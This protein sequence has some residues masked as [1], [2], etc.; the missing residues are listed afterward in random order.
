[1]PYCSIEYTLRKRFEFVVSISILHQNTSKYF[2]KLG[3][4][5]IFPQKDLG[6]SG[7]IGYQSKITFV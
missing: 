5:S 7:V 4:A 3:P 1:M 6:V 2:K